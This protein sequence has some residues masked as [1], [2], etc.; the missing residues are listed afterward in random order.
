MCRLE[1]LEVFHRADA[2]VQ[3]D[4]SWDQLVVRSQES[5]KVGDSWR[6][7][8]H[9]SFRQSGKL[10]SGCSEKTPEVIGACGGLESEANKEVSVLDEVLHLCCFGRCVLSVKL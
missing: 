1:N 2:P 4:H 8:L 5:M 3:V 6:G 9:G 7:L 10:I